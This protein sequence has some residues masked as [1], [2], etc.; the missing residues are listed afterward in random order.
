MRVLLVDDDDLLREALAR[1]LRSRGLN[2]DAA[3]GVV[4]ARDF[5]SRTTYRV[6]ISDENMLDGWG[7]DLL[8]H[9]AAAQP[10]CQRALVSALDAPMGVAIAWDRFFAKP[11]DMDALMKWAVAGATP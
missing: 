3:N 10:S 1:R 9:V 8:A 7:H 4:E 11:D 6:V 2:V 5:L